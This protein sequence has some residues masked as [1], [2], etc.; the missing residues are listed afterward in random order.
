MRPL[1][2]VGEHSTNFFLFLN[3]DTVLSFSKFWKS[4]LLLLLKQYRNIFK[5]TYENGR[6]I[7]SIISSL[8]FSMYIKI[9]TDTNNIIS[10]PVQQTRDVVHWRSGSVNHSI[11]IQQHKL[12]QQH[13]I[14]TPTRLNYCT[15]VVKTKR[16]NYNVQGQKKG[17]RLITK[18]GKLKGKR[19]LNTISWNLRLI[20]SKG[21]KKLQ[22]YVLGKR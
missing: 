18:E 9:I 7:I 5:I 21:L 20:V 4:K 8:T 11:R 3:L 6:S 2:G 10:N 22:R 19:K 13:L 15:H 14:W 17:L 16:G 12:T 1:Y